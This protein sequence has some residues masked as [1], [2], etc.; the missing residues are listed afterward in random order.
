[1]GKH[2]YREVTVVVK[3]GRKKWWEIVG[4]A[5]AQIDAALTLLGRRRKKGRWMLH[6][7]ACHV[8]DVQVS[9]SYRVEEL[10]KAEWESRFGFRKKE[11]AA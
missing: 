1:M 9:A 8:G 10:S 4:E 6:M 7:V 5:R 3:R 2:E 11:G